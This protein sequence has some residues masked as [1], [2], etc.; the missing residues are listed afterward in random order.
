MN[1]GQF[2]SQYSPLPSATVVQHLLAIA[3]NATGPG[4]TVFASRFCVVAT[5]NVQRVSGDQSTVESIFVHQKHETA[6]MNDDV[7][8]LLSES[9]LAYCRSITQQK[10]V[11]TVADVS[12]VKSDLDTSEFKINH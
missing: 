5:E 1:L 9:G 6:S 10:F 2:L 4:E 7:S 11:S 3:E 8:V 12:V